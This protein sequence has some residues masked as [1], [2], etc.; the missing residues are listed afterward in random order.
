MAQNAGNEA[1]C[2]IYC[3]IEIGNVDAST[4]KSYILLCH[5]TNKLQA[6]LLHMKAILFFL[7][8]LAL[9]LFFLLVAAQDLRDS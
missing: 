4:M 9:P 3:L 7:N 2:F 6:L 1:G 8:G 5:D